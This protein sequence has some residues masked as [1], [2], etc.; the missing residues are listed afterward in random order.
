[1]TN[2]E[3]VPGEVAG[4]AGGVGVA[5][6]VGVTGAV[7]VG[8]DAQPTTVDRTAVVRMATK[9]SL[10]REDEDMVFKAFSDVATG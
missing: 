7:A 1:M 6:L 3:P 10:A 8:S 9:A 5:G 4:G 2:C